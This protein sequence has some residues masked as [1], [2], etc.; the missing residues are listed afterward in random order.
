MF[1]TNCGNS[2]KEN[3]K[4]CT[5]CGK[6]I[7]IS[8]YSVITN[9]SKNIT[10]GTITI[11]RL[12]SFVGCIAPIDIYIDERKVGTLENDKFITIPISLG[13]HKIAF[14]SWKKD[15]FDIFITEKNPHLYG[16]M[17]IEMGALSN[18]F[19]LIHLKSIPTPPDTTM[20]QNASNSATSPKKNNPVAIASFILSIVG[21]F[22][23]LIPIPSLLGLIY[24]IAGKKRSDS[25]NEGNKGLAITAIILSSIELVIF[26]LIL[27]FI[28]KKS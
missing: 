4:F 10:S 12:N 2:I 19:K 5:N 20:S 28:T 25:L 23:M 24:G 1:C 27:L 7:I 3:N 26:L 6:E 9:T 16:D 14:H 21:L 22:C 17:I 15:K 18:N 8:N 13:S 11:H